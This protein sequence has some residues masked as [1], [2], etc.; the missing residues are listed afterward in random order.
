MVTNIYFAS[1][2]LIGIDSCFQ[3]NRLSERLG[4]E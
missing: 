3:D 1:L 2:K 4:A